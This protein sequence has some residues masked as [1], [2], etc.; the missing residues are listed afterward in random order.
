MT[1]ALHHGSEQAARKAALEVKILPP[2]TEKQAKC[3][4]FILAY[5]IKNRFYPTHREIAAAMGIRS[6]TA[7]MYLEPLE[8]KGYLLREEGKQRNLRLTPEALERL[9]LNGV[10][11]RERLPAA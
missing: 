3:L 1:E 8:R 4:E 11:V 5:L 2:L 6:S 10:D 9:E 7:E